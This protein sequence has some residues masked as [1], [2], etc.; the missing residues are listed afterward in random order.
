MPHYY[1]FGTV[2]KIPGGAALDDMSGG[3]YTTRRMEAGLGMAAL[4][5]TLEAKGVTP[6]MSV[7]ESFAVDPATTA[8]FV[9][10]QIVLGNVPHEE[11]AQ[12]KTLADDRGH[13]LIDDAVAWRIKYYGLVKRWSFR[14][15]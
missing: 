13:K 3:P 11:I 15:R 8:E 1:E 6:D 5:R 4:R 12:I 10:D 7:E 9:A 14:R 2:A